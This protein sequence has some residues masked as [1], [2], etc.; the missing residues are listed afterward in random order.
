MPALRKCCDFCSSLRTLTI[1]ISISSLLFNVA[2]LI[3]LFDGYFES[4]KENETKLQSEVQILIAILIAN[5][6]SLI[7]L[8]IGII[9][10]KSILFTPWLMTELPIWAVNWFY[11]SIEAG[12][13]LQIGLF[14]I[15]S[16]IFF[17]KR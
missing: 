13:I 17:S 15:S 4:I 8:L 9:V 14:I 2:Y 6:A 5:S 1:I 10:N 7:V 12:S 16:E 3:F 11:F